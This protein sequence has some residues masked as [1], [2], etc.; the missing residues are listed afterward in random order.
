MRRRRR[1]GWLRRFTAT[2]I[3]LGL[4]LAGFTPVPASVA[5]GEFRGCYWRVGDT[6]VIVCPDGRIEIS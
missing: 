6:T 5:D 2:L 4:A 3:A 1:L